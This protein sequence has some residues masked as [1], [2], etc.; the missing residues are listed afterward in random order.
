[1]IFEDAI[2]RVEA[3]AD[4]GE[5]QT[6][7]R[8]HVRIL[9]PLAR[10]EPGD[11]PHSAEGLRCVV[12][13]RNVA[14][15][16]ALRDRRAEAIAFLSFAF[17]SSIDLADDRQAEA[18]GRAGLAEFEGESIGHVPE[19]SR[20]PLGRRIEPEFQP[21]S[22]FEEQGGRLALEDADLAVPFFEVARQDR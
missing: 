15:L 10:H 22:P 5:V 14:D 13:P 4:L 11:L 9:R 3:V 7:V 19:A 12:D 1:M 21:Q 18:V 2:D 8:E 20:N 16:F 17:R 6:K